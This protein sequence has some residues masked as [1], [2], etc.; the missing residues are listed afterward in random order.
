MSTLG[1]RVSLSISGSWSRVRKTEEMDQGG[2]G[3]NADTVLVCC[4][5]E[6]A[7]PQGKALNLL[8]H[9]CPSPYLWSEAEGS[10]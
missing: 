10:D 2:I 4:G 9:A 3:S 5:E 1:Q 8:L 6:R 7:E